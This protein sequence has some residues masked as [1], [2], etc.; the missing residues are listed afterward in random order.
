MGCLFGTISREQIKAQEK[1]MLAGSLSCWQL[2]RTFVWWEGVAFYV[3]MAGGHPSP[4][5]GFLGKVLPWF[6]GRF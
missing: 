5:T 2:Q 6:L 1:Q 4:L 3:G